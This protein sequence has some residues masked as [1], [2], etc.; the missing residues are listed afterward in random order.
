MDHFD[1]AGRGQGG[2]ARGGFRRAGHLRHAFGARDHQH[3]PQ[4]LAATEQAVAHRLGDD[5]GR[6]G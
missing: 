3:R 2:V 6:F 5:V 4:S 1:G